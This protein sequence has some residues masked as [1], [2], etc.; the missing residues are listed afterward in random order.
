MRASE[1]APSQQLPL[2]KSAGSLPLSGPAAHARP[3][4]SPRGLRFRGEE[5]LEPLSLPERWA[6]P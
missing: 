5:V 6:E 2:L 4:R 1:P 3:A